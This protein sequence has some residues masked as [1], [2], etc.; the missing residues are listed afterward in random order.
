MG[1]G[2]VALILDVNGIALKAGITSVSAINEKGKAPMRLLFA[3]TVH[4]PCCCLTT[5]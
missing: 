2:E 1:D 4:I 3:V 5:R